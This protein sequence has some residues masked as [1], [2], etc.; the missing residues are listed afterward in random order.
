MKRRLLGPKKIFAQG[1]IKS[2]KKSCTL[3]N[4]KKYSCYG[5]KNFIQGI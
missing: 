1:K 2:K 5:L 4:P 3:I